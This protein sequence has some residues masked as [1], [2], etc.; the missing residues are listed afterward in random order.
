MYIGLMEGFTITSSSYVYCMYCAVCASAHNG[1]A[2]VTAS[3]LDVAI[4]FLF[5]LLE[6]EVSP[7]LTCS[8]WTSKISQTG[9]VCEDLM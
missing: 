2:T 4:G 5:C 7:R 3:K 6:E 8:S 1:E 9:L